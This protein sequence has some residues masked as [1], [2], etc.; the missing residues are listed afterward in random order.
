[1][2]TL[3]CLKCSIRSDLDAGKPLKLLTLELPEPIHLHEEERSSH[4]SQKPD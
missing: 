4:V 2:S 1:M 3:G